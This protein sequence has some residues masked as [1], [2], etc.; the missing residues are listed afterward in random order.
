[1]TEIQDSASDAVSRR[2]FLQVGALMGGL[3]AGGPLLAACS[4][5]SVSNASKVSGSGANVAP[6]GK[7]VKI[8]TTVVDSVI[9]PL[10]K[11]YGTY[12]FA[13]FDSLVRALDAGAQPE[14]RLATSWT[15]KPG[16]T[17]WVFTLRDGVKFHD[18]TA[19]TADDVV[20]TINEIINKKYG[21]NTYLLTVKSVTA[22]DAKT[23]RIE[24]TAPDPI[25]LNKLGNIFIVP[26]AYW[27]KVGVD[28][29]NKAPIGSGPFK[30]TSFSPD[31]GL[32]L[33]A[34]DGFW[35]P[36]PKTKNIKQTYFS[37]AGAMSSALQAGQIDIAHNLDASV[38]RTLKSAP[39]LSVMQGK[40]NGSSMF[41]LNTTKAPFDKLEARQA[42]ILALDA[43]ALVSALTY[44]TGIL[45]DGQVPLP[46]INGYTNTIKRPTQ[47]VDKAKQLLEQ[48]GYKGAT[49]NISGMALYKNQMEAIA[50]QLQAVGFAPKITANQVPA[51]VKQF[52]NGTDAEIFYR[53]ASYSG[54]LDADRVF[55]FVSFSSQP[56]VKDPNWDALLSAERAEM[57]PAKRQ[58][59]LIACSQYL[60][61]QSYILYT[62]GTATVGGVRNGISGISF[63][64]GLMLL[65]EQVVKA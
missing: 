26:K 35:G 36:P 14:P 45:E 4:H 37:D 43:P 13:A 27:Q 20:F 47:D 22:P 25:L 56:M 48:S 39:G 62:Y 15:R 1:M 33:E 57:D 44:G 24:T 65:L 46:G 40:G 12:Q 19:L 2:R 51:W 10:D 23:V 18:G 30:I 55:S 31:G 64:T 29:F 32:V 53:G 3:L 6:T 50:Q 59:K 5:S 21:L 11:Q 61:D 16:D 63:D 52:T 38:T 49:V 7:P 8:G 28:G 58:A 54:I 34:F 60:L 41:Q 9:Q 17:V 42:A